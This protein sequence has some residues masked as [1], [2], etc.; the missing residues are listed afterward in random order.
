MF[1]SYR[2]KLDVVGPLYQSQ[3]QIRLHIHICKIHW[4]YYKQHWLHRHL[5]LDTH[6]HLHVLRNV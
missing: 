3:Q 1:R 2:H 5:G 6:Q 4:C